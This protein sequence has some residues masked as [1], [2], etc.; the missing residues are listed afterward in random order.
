MLGNPTE[1]ALLLWL[2]S[3]GVDY[4]TIRETTKEVEELP[5][6]T[7]R[8]YMATHVESAALPGKRVL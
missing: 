3:N 2:Y 6:S 8:K 5:F 4:R 7:E 1:G